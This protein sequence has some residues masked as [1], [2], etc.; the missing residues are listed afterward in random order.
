MDELISFIG[1]GVSNIISFY[2]FKLAAD[3]GTPLRAFA[4]FRF[5]VAAI[6]AAIYFAVDRSIDEYL[7]DEDFYGLSA[8]AIYAIALRLF[9]VATTALTI[10]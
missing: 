1:S 9:A 2:A 6:V 10:G 7:N 4:L 5:G 3:A 8:D